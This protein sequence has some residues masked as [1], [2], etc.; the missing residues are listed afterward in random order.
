MKIQ[1]NIHYKTQ[2][3][4]SMYLLI[5]KSSE[6]TETD[7]GSTQGIVMQCNDKSEWKTE[8]TIDSV[9]SL[10]YQYAILNTDKTFEYEYGGIRKV[11][12]QPIKES[13]FI[14]DNWRASYGDSPF[15]TAAFSDC[16]FNRANQKRQIRIPTET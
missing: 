13:V 12:F 3:G 15:S 1:F 7:S 16:F 14:F 2:W 5:Y 4:Q 8:I 9:D 6:Q 11:L 10:S